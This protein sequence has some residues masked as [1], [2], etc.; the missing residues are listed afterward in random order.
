MLGPLAGLVLLMLGLVCHSH[1]A[2][3]CVAAFLGQRSLFY[4]RHPLL[5]AL[6][7]VLDPWG[8]ECGIGVPCRGEHTLLILYSLLV[9]YGGSLLISAYYKENPF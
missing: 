8:R 4:C 1:C 6:M 5:L 3:M 7:V 2:F 9:D